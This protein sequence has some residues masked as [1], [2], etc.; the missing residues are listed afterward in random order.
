MTD[1]IAEDWPVIVEDCVQTPPAFCTEDWAYI[2][3]DLELFTEDWC[4]L[5]KI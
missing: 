5:Y 1:H 3:K 2:D 4:K